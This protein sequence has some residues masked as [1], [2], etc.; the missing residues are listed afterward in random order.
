MP[1][2]QAEKFLEIAL[3][4]AAEYLAG[5]MVG[6]T[7]KILAQNTLSRVKSLVQGKT[8]RFGPTFSVALSRDLIGMSTTSEIWAIRNTTPPELGHGQSFTRDSHRIWG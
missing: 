2:L 4:R 8:I 7:I 6:G 1:K 5:G 3:H